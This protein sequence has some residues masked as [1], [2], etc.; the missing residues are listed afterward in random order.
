MTDLRGPVLD[1]EHITVTKGDA[2][3]LADV[4][5][6][7][8]PGEHWVVLGPNGAGKSTLLRVAAGQEFVADGVV[9]VLGAEASTADRTELAAQIGIASSDVA[10]R[11]PT[12]T[13]AL[14]AVAT[15]AWGQSS[16]YSEEYESQDLERARDLLSALGVGGVSDRPF[17]TLSEGEKR[18]VLLAR[19]LMSNPE[20]VVLDEPT[21]GLDL[22]GRELLIS[23]VDEIL[24]GRSAPTM[25]LITHEP[26]QIASGFTHA[27]ILRE[28]KVIAAGPLQQTINSEVLSEAFGIPLTVEHQGGRIVARAQREE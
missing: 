9:Q 17:S 26:E 20:I 13:S 11:I 6:T 28:G 19:A 1:L 8:G 5:W 12:E 18:R 4:S 16:H 2:Q 10:A 3:V 25:I 14:L 21:A 22:A 15:S 24:A 27:L 7:V 23:A